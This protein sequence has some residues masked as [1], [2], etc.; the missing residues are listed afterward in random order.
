MAASGKPVEDDDLIS[1]VIGGLNSSYHNFI[2][3][4]SFSTRKIVLSYDQFQTELL[5]H[6]ILLVNSRKSTEREIGGFALYS[7]KPKNQQ[8]CKNKFYGRAKQT[9][10]VTSSQP[11]GHSNSFH[12]LPSINK[13][14]CQICGKSGHQ[15]LDCFHRMDF[16]FK[17]RHPPTQLA[18][19]IAKNDS[20]HDQTWLADSGA[21]HHIIDDVN[22]LEINEPYH[23]GEE[24]SVGNGSGLFIAHTGS[25]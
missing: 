14:S 15:A 19:M 13:P 5:N 4:Y 10:V 9:S 22:N 3:L 17:G 6:E 12:S 16:S 2:S 23:G 8:F 7:Q 20:D 18:A 24:V 11:K 1:Y 21:N 25:S